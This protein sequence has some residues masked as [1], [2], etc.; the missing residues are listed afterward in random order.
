MGQYIVAR[1]YRNI[2]TNR[3]AHYIYI[4]LVSFSMLEALYFFAPVLACYALAFLLAASCTCSVTFLCGLPV[5]QK[6][7]VDCRPKI[8]QMMQGIAKA[9]YSKVL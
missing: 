1:P 6:Y 9:K 5:Q 3:H 7:V 4:E 8:S 2:A